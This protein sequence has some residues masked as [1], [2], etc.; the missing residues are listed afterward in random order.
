MPIS[1]G[2]EVNRPSPDTGETPLHSALC[3]A[4]R[5]AYDL[6]VKVLLAHG[7]NPNAATLP[8]AET[9]AFMSDCRTKAETPLFG[10][11]A[12]SP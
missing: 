2:G 7:A 4:N 8:S 9:G 5:P 3:K 1:A 6:V 12:P 11:L 10:K